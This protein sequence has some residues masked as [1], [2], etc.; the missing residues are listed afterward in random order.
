MPRPVL[1]ESDKYYIVL[2]YSSEQISQQDLADLYGVS[3]TTI[4]RVLAK[5]GLCI[6][7]HP[8]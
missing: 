2:E 1:S 6:Y 4:R 5:K 7:R 3:R 8:K